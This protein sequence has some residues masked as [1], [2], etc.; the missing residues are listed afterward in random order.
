MD[1]PKDANFR[2]K[3]G[4]RGVLKCRLA[5]KD[6]DTIDEAFG[7]LGPGH[8]KHCRLGHKRIETIHEGFLARAIDFMERKAKE[9]ARG[10]AAISTSACHSIRL[11]AASGEQ[12]VGVITARPCAMPAA[13]RVRGSDEAGKAFRVGLL[14]P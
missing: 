13:A 11:F 14:P 7:R 9:G 1:Y 5:D 10:S 2:K 12:C 3:F 4:P 6:N 8:R